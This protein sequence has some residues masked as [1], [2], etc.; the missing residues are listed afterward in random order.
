MSLAEAQRI[1]RHRLI[2]YR[3][4]A[5]HLL[6]GLPLSGRTIDPADVASSVFYIDNGGEIIASVRYVNRLDHR[7]PQFDLQSFGAVCQEIDDGAIEIA[8][9]FVSSPYRGTEVVDKLLAVSS[10]QI[11]TEH[12]ANAGWFA[13][14]AAPLARVFAQKYAGTLSSRKFHLT[15]RD[16]SSA[17]Y[18]MVSGSLSAV[19]DCAHHRL[20]SAQHR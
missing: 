15:R 5:P 17:P 18:L 16:G 4:S 14:S 12:P 13:V 3:D 6:A 9:L 19:A 20:V 10:A 1:Q 7:C 2:A 11:N 8:R